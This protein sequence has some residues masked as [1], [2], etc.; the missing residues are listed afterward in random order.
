MREGGF[1][2]RRVKKIIIM[3]KYPYSEYV[4]IIVWNVKYENRYIYIHILTYIHTVT[5][6]NLQEYILMGR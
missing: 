6:C 1:N 3:V 2:T 5:S 4:I